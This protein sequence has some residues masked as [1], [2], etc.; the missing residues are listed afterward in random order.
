L[1][2]DESITINVKIGEIISIIPQSTALLKTKN[3]N[4]EL[5][6]EL[7]ELGV[8]EGARNQAIDSQIDIDILSGS[9]LLFIDEHLP[10]APEY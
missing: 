1:P 6:N 8:R 4:W 9:I 10:F 3:L 2:I 7:L 5:N